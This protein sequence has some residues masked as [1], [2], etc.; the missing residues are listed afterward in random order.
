MEKN[1]LAVANAVKLIK[2]FDFKSPSD[3]DFNKIAENDFVHLQEKNLE[4]ELGR[5]VI[6]DGVAVITINNNIKS[7]TRKR[8]TIAHEFGHFYNE[9]GFQV[10]DRLS[11]SCNF[12]NIFGK[13]SR[14]GREKNA[15][16]F[17]AELLMHEEWFNDFTKNREV[18]NDLLKEIGEYFQVSLT[19]AAI[20][21]AEIGSHPIATIFVRDSMVKWSVINT[22]FPYKFIQPNSRVSELSYV[23]EFF[24]GNYYPK[25][26]EEILMK[27]WF[28]SDY[29]FKDQNEKVNEIIIPFEHYYDSVLV[30]LIEK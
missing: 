22:Y 21:Y 3:I 29:R 5:I 4:N 26:G 28:S 24:D 23:S 27:A 19:A 2:R 20:R 8:F 13:Y 25:E 11:Y 14:N 12:D 16:D 6:D 30:L 9:R 10:K 18:D 1:N 15:N 7:A 17:A